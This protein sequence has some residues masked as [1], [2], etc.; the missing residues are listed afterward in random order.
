MFNRPCLKRH[1]FQ[2]VISNIAHHTFVQGHWESMYAYCTWYVSMIAVP[3]MVHYSMKHSPFSM[4]KHARSLPKA[5]ICGQAPV[6]DT[7]LQ[8]CMDQHAR[9]HTHTHKP[10]TS[11]GV[12]LNDTASDGHD[13]V[14]S[15]HRDAHSE[16]W[17]ARLSVEE[18]HKDMGLEQR[19]EDRRHK[20]NSH[21]MTSTNTTMVLPTQVL[22]KLELKRNDVN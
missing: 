5:E 21:V 14:T 20:A 11:E 18:C 8:T 2:Y 1:V 12:L 4:H 9:M 3:N 16:V 7:R 6:T 17:L 13:A 10:T 19:E 22:I 15:K